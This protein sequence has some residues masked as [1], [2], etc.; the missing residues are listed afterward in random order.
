[1]FSGVSITT[2]YRRLLPLFLLPPLRAHLL[3]SH[4][5]PQALARIA[6]H[7]L[8]Q[9]V[10]LVTFWLAQARVASP[11]PLTARM[12]PGTGSLTLSR[13]LAWLVAPL[14]LLRTPHTC[15]SR[16]TLPAP[17]AVG[18]L[19][20]SALSVVE[21]DCCQNLHVFFPAIAPQDLIQ[22]LQRARVRGAAT[23]APQQ[24]SSNRC[25]NNRVS[26]EA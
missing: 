2:R 25:T 15:A 18:H 10:S 19:H 9:P 24:V 1:M 21:A 22:I 4:P 14:V 3:L 20:T 26:L 17:S 5:C 8:A 16:V 13:T 23:H 12:M 6:L 7:P 11:H